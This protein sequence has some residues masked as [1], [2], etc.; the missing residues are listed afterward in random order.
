[1][2]VKNIAIAILFTVEMMTGGQNRAKKGNR[3][4]LKGHEGGGCQ[5]NG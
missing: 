4:P 3:R 1:M 5:L 2:K